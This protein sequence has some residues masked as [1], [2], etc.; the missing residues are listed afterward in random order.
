MHGVVG[1]WHAIADNG[2]NDGVIV[3]RDTGKAT[4]LIID[5]IGTIYASGA[6]GNGDGGNGKVS[7]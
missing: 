7:M 6:A 1:R 5:A 2:V 4:G 3:S